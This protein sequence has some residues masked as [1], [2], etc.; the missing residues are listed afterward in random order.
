VGTKVKEK[1]EIAEFENGKSPNVFRGKNGRGGGR[2][3]K[4]RVLG[5]KEIGI[6]GKMEMCSWGE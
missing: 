5:I 4:G 6:G 2:E 3:G 1:V